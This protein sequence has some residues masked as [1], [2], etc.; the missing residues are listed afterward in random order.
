MQ[1]LIVLKTTLKIFCIF[2]E[3]IGI[4]SLNF[5]HGNNIAEGSP[6]FI[7]CKIG[8]SAKNLSYSWYS[9]AKLLSNFNDKSELLIAKSHRSNTG[10]YRC[11]VK[12]SYEKK[13]S[14]MVMVYVEC[15]LLTSQVYLFGVD[16]S[17]S[18]HVHVVALF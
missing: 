17:M 12:D 10:E 7:Q 14:E 1:L 9:G 4:P 2:V 11:M 15:E 3:S 8:N 6:L 16:N 18:I 13:S 5:I